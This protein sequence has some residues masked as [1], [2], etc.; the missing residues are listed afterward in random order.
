MTCLKHKFKK[1]CHQDTQESLKGKVIAAAVMHKHKVAFGLN[2]AKSL[3]NWY[4][5][6]SPFALLE[7]A[8]DTINYICNSNGYYSE[9]VFNELN[10]WKILVSAYTEFEL[11]TML[12]PVFEKFRFIPM[13]FQFENGSIP[14]VYKMPVGTIVVSNK[15]IFI[16]KA[17]DE[18]VAMD[19]LLELKLQGLDSKMFSLS[20]KQGSSGGGAT[21]GKSS[22]DL[23]SEKIAYIPSNRSDNF[24]KH[25]RS[26]QKHGMNRALLFHGPPG[27]GKT[28]LCQTIIKDLDLVTLKFRYEPYKLPLDLVKYIVEKFRVEAVIIDDFDQV[29]NSNSLLEFLEWLKI[30]TKLVMSVSNSL[31]EFHPAILRPG[32]FDEIIKIDSLEDE[33]LMQAL[34]DLRE[35]YKD[36]VTKWPVAYINELVNRSKIQTTEELSKSYEE[37]NERVEKQLEDLGAPAKE[38]NG[39]ASKSNGLKLLQLHLPLEL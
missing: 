39:K 4:V 16:E 34:G 7:G 27:T 13:Q 12:L 32:R 8:F 25:I 37:L 1:F 11:Y 18:E 23:V 19:Y 17:V 26:Y 15:G 28:T 29:E 20:P 14:K 36:K 31:K 22:A 38:G 9:S 30:N 6:K 33:T 24:V 3:N 2:I 35:E 5:D 21:Y 10:G